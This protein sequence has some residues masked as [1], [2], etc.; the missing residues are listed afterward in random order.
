MAEAVVA[1]GEKD[2][3]LGGRGTAEDRV[4]VREAAEALDD[5]EVQPRHVAV[6]GPA[7]PPW[8]N[9]AWG[10]A[11][12]PVRFAWLLRNE[13]PDCRQSLDQACHSVE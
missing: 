13:V 9:T 10:E 7:G 12:A 6:G 2:D 1:F 4:A 3:L 8:A 11:T 5:F